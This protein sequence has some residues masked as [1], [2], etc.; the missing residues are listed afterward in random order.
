MVP[1]KPPPRRGRAERVVVKQEEEPEAEDV[2]SPLEEK[3]STERE[4]K[5]EVK[6]EKKEENQDVKEK[7]ELKEK[8]DIKPV[9]TVNIQEE[10]SEKGRWLRNVYKLSLFIWV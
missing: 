3:E 10:V 6:K 1:V 8:K 4:N 5:K 2:P 9:E 7:K